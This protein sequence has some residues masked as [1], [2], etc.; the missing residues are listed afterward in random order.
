MSTGYL[1]LYCERTDGAFWSEP[2][3][4]LT[5]VV[6]LLAA[7]AA[8]RLLITYRYRIRGAGMLWLLLLLA[9]G[10]GVG[11]FLFHTLAS[12]WAAVADLL[13]IALFAMV[14]LGT[15][16]SRFFGYPPL[17]V[18]VM[19]SGVAGLT[20][21]LH[22]L[23]PPAWLNGSEVYLVLLATLAWLGKNLRRSDEISGRHL[24]FMA[25]TFAV[26]LVF[27][28]VD[29]WVCDWLPIGTHFLWHL[30]NGSVVYGMLAV[31]ID[32]SMRWYP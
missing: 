27:R 5:N 1:D 25:A 3:N 13:P 20:L 19:I 22:V 21:L 28:S 7:A 11:S 14:A 2:V 4:A 16:L 17:M 32:R 6:F 23:I 10:I 26:S 24:Q 29:L 15:I 8:L 30:L 18:A 12:P 9:V 31:L